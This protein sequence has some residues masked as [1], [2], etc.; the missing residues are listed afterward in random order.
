VDTGEKVYQ[1]TLR[2]TV[3]IL[4]VRDDHKLATGTG[5]IIDLGRRLVL[6]N[7]H[8]VGDDPQAYVLFPIYRHGKPVAERSEYIQLFRNGTAARGRVRARDVRRDLA[9]IELDAPAPGGVTYLRLG[10]ESPGPGQRVHSIG[11]PGLSGALWVYTSGT[12]RAVYHK[13]WQVQEGSRLL[14]FNAEVVETQS[15][16]NPGDSGGPLVN[17]R[18][19]LVAVTQGY[20]PAGQLLSNFIDVTE[21]RSFLAN[22]HL[23]SKLPGP[24]TPDTLTASKPAE[25]EPPQVPTKDP[26]QEAET[27]ATNKLNFAR[28]LAD[29]GRLEKAKE[30]CEEIINDFPKTKAALEAKTLLD[31]LNK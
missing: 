29:A 13:Q 2:S 12:V 9:I 25:T 22:Q 24:G 26:I 18:G 21:V 19:E 8:V 27:R 11:N 15:P 20:N 31:K 28:T 1:R 4:S 10:R 17:D 23:L 3:W 14:T 16:T 7:Y 30:R 5:T 6:T